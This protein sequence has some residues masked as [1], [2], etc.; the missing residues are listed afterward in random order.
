MFLSSLAALYFSSVVM[1]ISVPSDIGRSASPTVLPV[2]ISGPFYCLF[3]YLPEQFLRVWRTYCIKGNCQWS[4]RHVTLSFSCIV[5][6]RLVIA[7]FTVGE[8]HTDDI[9][10]SFS[11]HIYFFWRIGFG[12]NGADYGGSSIIGFG[13]K[14]GIQA[15]YPFDLGGARG[16]MIQSIGHFHCSF[17]Q[18]CLIL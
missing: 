3:K 16:Q 1:F 13:L 2:R 9:E 15:G 17:D 8:I 6:H 7:V 12:P 10:P 4:T 5:D 18:R 14:L 11:Q